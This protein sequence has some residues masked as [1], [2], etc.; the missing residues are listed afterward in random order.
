MRASQQSTNVGPS[1]NWNAVL[2]AATGRYIKLLPGD[3]T[4]HPTCLARQVAAL[5][6]AEHEDVVLVCGR[7]DVI[8]ASGRRVLTAGPTREGRIGG[9]AM[10]RRTI[11]RGTN[12]IGEPG[13]VLFRASAAHA[14]G[15]FNGAR[16]YVIDLEY[17]SRLLLH[18]AAYVVAE[19]VCTFRLSGHNWTAALSAVRRQHFLA[20]IDQM[21]ATSNVLSPVDRVLGRVMATVNEGLRR[22]VHWWVVG[23]A[24]RR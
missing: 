5:E 12:I 4:L 22:L 8:D 3:D 17:W 14:V 1:A 23:W 11:R 21:T 16:G 9:G 2:A 18:G 20:L 15:G 13:A 6:H 19:P 10:M 7:R 24:D